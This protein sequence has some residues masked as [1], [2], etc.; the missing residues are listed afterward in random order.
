MN[1]K[2]Q[3]IKLGSEQPSLQDDIRVVLDRLSTEKTSQRKRSFD[4][5][6]ERKGP[7]SYHVDTRRHGTVD[8]EKLDRNSW[9]A[10]FGSDQ[11][12]VEEHEKG[13]FESSDYGELAE[14]AEDVVREAAT[15]DRGP[16][17]ERDF[18]EW[19]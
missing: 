12:V 5:S 13:R 7:D 18:Q 11:Y 16:F 14:L 10:D 9:I 1:L 8:V 3:L 17:E 15:F 6:V 4:L 2:D 19:S